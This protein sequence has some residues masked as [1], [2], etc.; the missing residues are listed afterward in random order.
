MN[1]VLTHVTKTN[2]LQISRILEQVF[3][4]VI[5]IQVEFAALVDAR[6][7]RQSV[8]IFWMAGWNKSIAYI[9]LD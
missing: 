8:L 7:E 5:L 3:I 1:A 6:K 2:E 9:F 4:S